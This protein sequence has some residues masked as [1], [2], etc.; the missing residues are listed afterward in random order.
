MPADLPPLSA[1]AAVE[2]LE[3][4]HE[5]V[6][7]FEAQYFVQLRR[8]YD[9]QLDLF[10]QTAPSTLPPRLDSPFDEDLPF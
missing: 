4:L 8:F 3:F 9:Q 5:L 2:I 10:E 6:F 1:E 7:R